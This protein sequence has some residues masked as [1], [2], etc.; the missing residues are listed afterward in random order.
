MKDEQ[1]IEVCAKYLNEQERFYDSPDYTDML[2]KMLKDA[3]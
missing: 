2:D 1:I 3:E